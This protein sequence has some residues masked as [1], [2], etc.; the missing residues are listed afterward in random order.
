MTYWARKGISANIREAYS[1]ICHN[2][3]S[4]R[5]DPEDHTDDDEIILIGFSRGAFTVRSV[6]SLIYDVGVLTKGGLGA[7]REVFDIWEEQPRRSREE[8]R[9]RCEKLVGEG[10]LLKDVPIRACAVWDTVG[11]LGIPKIAFL[12]QP[13][14][15]KLAFVNSKVCPNI[16]NA[17][18]ALALNEHRKSFVPTLWQKPTASNQTLKQC[19]FLGCHSDVGGGNDRA[20]LS[21]ISLVWMIDQLQS[22]NILDLELKVLRDFRTRTTH[23]DLPSKSTGVEINIAG[24]LHYGMHWEQDVFVGLSRCT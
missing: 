19:W 8:L 12:P 6:A 1:F 4:R 15:R 7:L 14:S 3:L 10:E 11:S 5:P 23:T 22:R 16:E 9:A 2:F 18:Q 21:N 20:S 24:I 13:G 17:F